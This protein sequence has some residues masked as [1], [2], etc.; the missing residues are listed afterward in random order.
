MRKTGRNL[1]MHPD[2]SGYM[3]IVGEM[4]DAS[5]VEDWA[6]LSICRSTKYGW[7][8]FTP[9]PLLPL[10]KRVPLFYFYMFYLIRG[11]SSKNNILKSLV[12]THIL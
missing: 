10:G 4:F 5:K 9:L 3:G 2:I 7:A 11:L 6:P 12:S 1:A 8:L